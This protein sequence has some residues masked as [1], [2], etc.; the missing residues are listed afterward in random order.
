[1]GWER[2]ALRQSKQMGRAGE[3]LLCAASQ[4]PPLAALAAPCP[5][6]LLAS[7][8][9][10]RRG[11]G[12]RRSS[13]ARGKALCTR[14]PTAALARIII[15]ATIRIMG[16]S[17]GGGKDG[18]MWSKKNQNS[19]PIHRH[20]WKQCGSLLPCSPSSNKHRACLTV[21]PVGWP[22]GSVLKR[23]SALSSSTAPSC[24]TSE[25]RGAQPCSVGAPGR[26]PGACWAQQRWQTASL[27]T[28]CGA[29]C[30]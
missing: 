10:S 5:A 8:S 30:T 15:S 11:G 3:G 19:A 29:R 1:M 14:R 9:A 4:P 17:C 27:H 24:S 20:W 23:S 28:A 25:R 6:A 22:A 12:W 26:Q 2:P 7:A 16:I 13:A 21:T 18:A